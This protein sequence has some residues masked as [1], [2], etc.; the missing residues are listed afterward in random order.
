MAGSSRRPRPQRSAETFVQHGGT[1][2]G[3][4]AMIISLPQDSITSIVLA[5]SVPAPTGRIARDL[6]AIVLGEPYAVAG[7]TQPRSKPVSPTE[8]MLGSTGGRRHFAACCRAATDNDLRLI[9]L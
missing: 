9:E 7:S 5:N 4:S 1:I 8:A 2:N 6:V 3:F